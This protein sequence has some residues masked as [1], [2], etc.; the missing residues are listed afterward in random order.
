MWTFKSI[1]IGGLLVITGISVLLLGANT[2]QHPD[3]INSEI[4]KDK[5]LEN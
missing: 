3:K 2:H 4:I 1:S 5:N